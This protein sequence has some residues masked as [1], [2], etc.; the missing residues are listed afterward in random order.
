MA[1]DL[2]TPT[3]VDEEFEDTYKKCG[4]SRAEF[5]NV[6]KFLYKLLKK[7]RLNEA[8]DEGQ[9]LF[10]TLEAVLPCIQGRGHGQNQKTVEEWFRISCDCVLP[11]EGKFVFDSL[12]GRCFTVFD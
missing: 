6:R 1:L 5:V 7:R 10:G 2:L 9:I 8:I 11:L 12:K 3:L 4:V